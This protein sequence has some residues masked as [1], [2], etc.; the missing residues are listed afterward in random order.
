MRVLYEPIKCFQLILEKNYRMR[1]E[2]THYIVF[3]EYF[4]RNLTRKEGRRLPLEQAIENPTILELKLAA[5][6][7]ECDFKI[8]EDAAYPRQWW[9]GKGLIL[10][11]KKAPKLQTLRDLSIAIS[12]FI[13][14]ALEKQKKQLIEKAKKRRT[15][16]GSPKIKSSKKDKQKDFR[17]KRRK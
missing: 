17:P 14:P 2:N 7:L 6:K 13:R 3:P 12:T 10:V 15:T 16:K 9:N 11:E 8:Q 1:R 5:Q 4:D